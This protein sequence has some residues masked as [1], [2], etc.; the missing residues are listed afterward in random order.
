[1]ESITPQLKT[2]GFSCHLIYK[3]VIIMK[4]EYIK[5]NLSWEIIKNVTNSLTNQIYFGELKT[6]GKIDKNR[7]YI[8]ANS[9]GGR[10]YNSTDIST[11]GEDEDV[12]DSLGA[13]GTSFMYF[14][15]YSSGNELFAKKQKDNSWNLEYVPDENNPNYRGYYF[16]MWENPEKVAPLNIEEIYQSINDYKKRNKN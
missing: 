7:A 16:E 10:D 4:T 11:L 15:S 9:Y 13:E 12:W 3:K 5:E 1:M 14:S 6:P 2:E 8:S